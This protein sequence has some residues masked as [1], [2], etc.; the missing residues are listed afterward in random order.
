MSFLVYWGLTTYILR[1]LGACLVCSFEYSTCSLPFQICFQLIRNALQSCWPNSA[2]SHHV[3]QNPI[4]RALLV[5]RLPHPLSYIRKSMAM[6]SLPYSHT[7][8]AQSILAT[9]T[10]Y[11]TNIHPEPSTSTV[12]QLI[13]CGC[14]WGTIGIAH[15][16]GWKGVKMHKER[17]GIAGLTFPIYD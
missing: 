15:A 7:I 1:Q 9:A 8:R 13:I 12:V 4:H 3:I 14:N 2:P 17:T 10:K 11:K 6:P 16:L 5:K